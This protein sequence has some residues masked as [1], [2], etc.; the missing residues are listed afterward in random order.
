VTWDGAGVSLHQ[1]RTGEARSRASG[2]G[3]DFARLRE[4]RPG[5]PPRHI[6]WRAWARL[7]EPM[8]KEFHEES[9]S[10]NALVLDTCAPSAC[11]RA[12]FEEAVSVAASFVAEPGWR[13]GKLDL[14]FTGEDTVH[15]TQGSAGE[16]VGRMLEA[17]AGVARSDADRFP[18]LAQAVTRRIGAFGACV[19]VLLDLDAERAQLVRALHAARVST[20]VLVVAGDATERVRSG[21]AQVP[22]PS[23]V[24]DVKPGQAARVLSE[25][26]GVRSAVP[27]RG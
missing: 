22:D 3:S 21:V 2:A 1:P 8:V 18:R 12:S 11:S 20:L 24:F 26:T 13:R 5:D 23:R 19:L 15:L 25:L 7:G 17:L 27:S 6:H 4:Y 9:P 10:R 14:L 16:G